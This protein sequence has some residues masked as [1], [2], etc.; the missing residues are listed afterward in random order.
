MI[1]TAPENYLKEQTMS[2]FETHLQSETFI[3]V[4]R[5]YIVN[6]KQIEKIELLEK[7]TYCIFLKNKAKIKAS[8][9]GYKLLKQK[10]LL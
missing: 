9:N 3:R 1:Y 6:I 7:E 10:L 5:S 4:H 2:F 8:K